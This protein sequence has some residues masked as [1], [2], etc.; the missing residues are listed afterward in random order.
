MVWFVS[1]FFP[2]SFDLQM[3]SDGKVFVLIQVPLVFD[4]AKRYVRIWDEGVRTKSVFCEVVKFP[5]DVLE[6]IP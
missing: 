6:A 2:S 3:N 1:L 5:V 4:Y